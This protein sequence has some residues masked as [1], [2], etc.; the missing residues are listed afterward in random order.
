[1]ATD[2]K[3]KS[4]RNYK[5]AIKCK[6]LLFFLFISLKYM[7]LYKAKFVIFYYEAYDT[8]GGKTW[9]QLHVMGS[10]LN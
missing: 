2:V 7:W 4:T 1:M 3:G 10:K 9:P 8:V 5:H 6:G